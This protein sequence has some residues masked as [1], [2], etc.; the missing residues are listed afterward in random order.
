MGAFGVKQRYVID[1]D[2]RR[3]IPYASDAAIPG[4]EWLKR[5]YD[6]G[7]LDPNFVTNTTADMRNLFLADRLGMNT[8]WD[9]WVGLYNNTRLNE[10]PNTEFRA[11]GIAGPVGPNGERM[12]R[13]GDPSIWAIPIN[14]QSRRCQEVLGVL[15]H[16]PVSAWVR[17][18]LGPYP[19]IRTAPWS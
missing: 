1:E 14:A 10:D 17:S 5:L 8:Y 19:G 13:R 11:M 6:E 18:V 15:R 9:M 16:R 2:G 12:L 7:I 4:Y 3:T